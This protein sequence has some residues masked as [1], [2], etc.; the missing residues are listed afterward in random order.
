MVDI[1]RPATTV[2]DCGY[3]LHLEVGPGLLESVYEAVLAKRLYDLGMTVQRQKAVSMQIDGIVFDD[4]FRAD[5]LVNDPLLIELKSIE[6]LSSLHTKQVLTYLRCLD[7]PLGLLMN[8]GA[9]YYKDGVKRV[10]NNHRTWHH[11]IF[12]F[13]FFLRGFSETHS[14]ASASRY[15]DQPNFHAPVGRA[16]GFVEIAGLGLALAIALGGKARL[17]DAAAAEVIGNRRSAALG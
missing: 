12:L 13:P 15:R 14:P 1:E 4:A 9:E 16:A 5:L 6:K 11:S 17:V 3:H 10:V 8:F 7:L 2:I